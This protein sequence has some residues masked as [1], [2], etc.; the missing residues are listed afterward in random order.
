MFGK[1]EKSCNTKTIVIA[2][3][4]VAII[5]TAGIAAIVLLAVKGKEE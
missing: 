2:A 1:K 4:A 3:V 5:M